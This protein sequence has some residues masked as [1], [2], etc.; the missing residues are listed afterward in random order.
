MRLEVLDRFRAVSIMLI[1]VGHSMY[2]WGINTF[3]EKIIANIITGGSALFVF[4][5]GFFFHYIF[6]KKFSYKE[7]MEKKIKNVFIPYL[8]ISVVAIVVYV[9]TGD[10][11]GSSYLSSINPT[12]LIGDFTIFFK[13]ILN[14]TAQDQ[15]W[16]IPFIMGVFLISPIIIFTLKLPFRLLLV[17][18]VFSLLL[19]MI[20]HRPVNFS[21]IVHS[22]IYFFPM[23]M[24]GI[25][26]SIK[27]ISY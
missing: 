18:F 25:I 17:L 10:S 5:S 15:L 24:L 21:D 7:F 19:A 14:G 9:F 26:V 6:Y 23:Y 3:P 2:P 27:N 16:Y 4:I 1:V 12:I 13:V 20:V 11:I 22:I 8:F